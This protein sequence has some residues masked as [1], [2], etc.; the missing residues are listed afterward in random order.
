MYKLKSIKLWLTVI[1]LTIS[2]IA[3]FIGKATFT[4][5]IAVVNIIVGLF[6]VANVSQKK[7]LKT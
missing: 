2:T 4:Q 3:L 5:W 6:F 7:V 1:V